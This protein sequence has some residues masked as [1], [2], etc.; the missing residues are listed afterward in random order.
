MDT[1]E[2][3]VPNHSDW[4]QWATE[5]L[6]SENEF[7]YICAGIAPGTPNLTSAQL[8]AVEKARE[9]ISRA[10][11]ASK[12]PFVPRGDASAASVLYGTSRHFRPPEV[13]AWAA[14]KFTSFP[15]AVRDAL[16]TGVATS[17]SWPWGA[18][19]TEL[20][21]KLAAAV[22]RYW[23]RYDPSDSSTASTSEDVTAWIEQQGVSKR[24]AEVMAQIIRADGLRT[25]PRQ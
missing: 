16:L 19:E 8:A 13:V 22:E 17:R 6:W 12:L 15:I 23:I 5:D 24:V 4:S 20:L 25:G 9:R 14:G 2:R 21:C 10:V 18:Y 11:H 3:A 7:A 1:K